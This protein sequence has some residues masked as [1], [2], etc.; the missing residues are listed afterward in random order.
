M[1]AVLRLDGTLELCQF[2]EGQKVERGSL[3]SR[4]PLDQRREV[5]HGLATTSGVTGPESDVMLEAYVD[6]PELL[7]K[8]E[9]E[10]ELEDA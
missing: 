8:L 3:L 7:V 5:F 9:G 2:L 4:M 6:V 10:E 1:G